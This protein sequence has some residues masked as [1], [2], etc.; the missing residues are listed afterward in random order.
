MAKQQALTEM[1]CQQDDTNGVCTFLTYFY[2]LRISRKI[3]LSSS[4]LPAMEGSPLSS[5][6]RPPNDPK[7]S[8][9]ERKIKEANQET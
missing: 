5:I 6:R 1:N 9:N 7:I 3:L 2:T 8:L 4:K